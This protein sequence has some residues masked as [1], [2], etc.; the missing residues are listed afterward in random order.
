[1][2][3]RFS[4]ENYEKLIIGFDCLLSLA[5]KINDKIN[6]H[7]QAQDGYGPKK[8]VH[9]KAKSDFLKVIYFAQPIF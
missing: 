6:H 5:L 8:K 2:F 7:R 1:M 4:G 9:H 3:A